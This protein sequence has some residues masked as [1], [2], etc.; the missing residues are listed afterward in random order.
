MSLFLGVESCKFCRTWP[1]GGDEFRENAVSDQTEVMALGEMVCLNL[2]MEWERTDWHGK[3]RNAAKETT[4]GRNLKE[5][6]V[7]KESQ[8][9]D[10]GKMGWRGVL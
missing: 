4:V 10:R 8:K 9:E 5:M 7:G 6:K 3:K 1:C 2:I